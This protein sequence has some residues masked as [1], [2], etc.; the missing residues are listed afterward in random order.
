MGKKNKV[1]PLGVSTP[2]TPTTPKKEE[3]M[4]QSK[5][6]KKKKKLLVK[7]EP[8]KFSEECE[9]IASMFKEILAEK[10]ETIDTPIIY[11]LSD[12]LSA[13]NNPLTK[14]RDQD[15]LKIL[16]LFFIETGISKEENVSEVSNN[17]LQVLYAKEILKKVEMLDTTVKVL[18][19]AI[20]LNRTIG[21]KLLEESFIDKVS[22]NTNVILFVFF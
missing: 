12:I 16:N 4:F 17:L 14:I 1:V 2:V 21:D 5:N 18:E 7:K 19:N 15:V 10:Y 8:P 13:Q 3:E 9:K 20:N 22:V 6:Q 11:Y